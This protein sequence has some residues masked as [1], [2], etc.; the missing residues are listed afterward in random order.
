[1]PRTRKSL[2][3]HD[4]IVRKLA[5]LYKDKGYDVDADLKGWNKPDTIGGVRLDLR[6]KKG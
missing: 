1:M 5:N 6:G 4:S 2:S 3:K